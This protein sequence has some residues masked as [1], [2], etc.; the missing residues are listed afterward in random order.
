LFDAEAAKAHWDANPELRPKLWTALKN[1]EVIGAFTAEEQTRLNAMASSEGFRDAVAKNEKYGTVTGSDDLDMI[2]RSNFK[3]IGMAVK[4]PVALQ[5]H[6]PPNTVPS[7]MLSDGAYMTRAFQGEAKTTLEAAINVLTDP[8]STE[9]Q[10]FEAKEEINNAAVDYRF[11]ADILIKEKE[12]ED[13]KKAKLP[14]TVKAFGDGTK[15]TLS[16]VQG[17]LSNNE[18]DPQ[19]AANAA[20]AIANNGLVTLLQMKAEISEISPELYGKAYKAI[21]GIEDSNYDYLTKENMPGEIK[22]VASAV[23]KELRTLMDAVMTATPSER[24]APPAGGETKA[25]AKTYEEDLDDA[26]GLYGEDPKKVDAYL[27]ERGH[28]IPGK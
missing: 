25:K 18:A 16:L 28:K 6:F 26:I 22:K 17:L 11:H 1:T 10:Q 27:L 14:K 7:L 12:A 9:E 8:K 21:K 15:E 3:S 2:Y 20:I 19:V 4:N 5:K 13:A 23:N 24:K